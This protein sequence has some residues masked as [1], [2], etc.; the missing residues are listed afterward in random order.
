MNRMAI[1]ALLA[2]AC[3]ACT[4]VRHAPAT[5]KVGATS[6]TVS[7]APA[8]TVPPAHPEAVYHN[9][10]IGVIYLRAHEDADGRLFGPQ[11]VYQI[12][13]PGGW[14]VNSLDQSGAYIPA[15]NLEVPADATS[16]SLAPARPAP[17]IPPDTPM[18]DPAKSDKI[19]ITGLMRKEDQAQAEAM[20]RRDGEGR[21]AVFD[22]EAGW[23]LMPVTTPAARPSP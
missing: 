3:S 18:L 23:L 4:S 14:N 17:P 21:V 9:P 11:L 1:V 12:T 6:S 22:S 10:K 20:A 13:D 7:L 15:P 8:M 2:L 5:V 16:P 19:V